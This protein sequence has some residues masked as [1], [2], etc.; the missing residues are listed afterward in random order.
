VV[1]S[2]SSLDIVRSAVAVEVR[3][4]EILGIASGSKLRGRPE[5]TGPIG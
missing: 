1:F 3:V 4:D 2:E 5:S